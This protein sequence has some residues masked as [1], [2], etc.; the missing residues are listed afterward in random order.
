MEVFDKAAWHIDA[1]EDED[2]VLAKFKAVMEFLHQKGLLSEEG[3]ELWQFG[4]DDSIALTE[5]MVTQ[6][7]AE[8]LK[9]H[10]DEVL[11]CG[12]AQIAEE[13]GRRYQ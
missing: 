6:K 11:D 7:G 13:L 8:F 4:V 12:A 1:G 9:R 5:E 10:Y 3:Q 2:E